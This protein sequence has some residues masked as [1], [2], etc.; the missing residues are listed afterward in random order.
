[1]ESP[2]RSYLLPR[3]C[4]GVSDGEG[5]CMCGYILYVCSGVCVCVCLEGEGTQTQKCHGA[6]SK[7]LCLSPRQSNCSRCH[8]QTHRAAKLLTKPLTVGERPHG[9]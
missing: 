8:V 7:Q 6:L 5:V 9:R 1:M 2:I 3:C 4:C